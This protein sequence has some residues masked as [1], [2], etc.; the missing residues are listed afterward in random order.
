EQYRMRSVD[1]LQVVTGAIAAMGI[2][3]LCLALAGLYGLV[4]YAVSRRTKEIGIRLAIGAEGGDVLKMV[5]RHGMRLALAGLGIGVLGAMAASRAFVA[6][7]P[8]G[9]HGDGRMD[10]AAFVFVVGTV[11]TVTFVATYVPARRAS[12]IS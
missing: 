5:L 11:L 10:L 8:G 7:F 3:G 4:A 9:P 6:V 2:M 12:R 1:V